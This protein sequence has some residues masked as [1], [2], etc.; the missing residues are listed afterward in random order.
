MHAHAGVCV[1]AGVCAHA[2]VCVCGFEL[3]LG[4]KLPGN[5]CFL[6]LQSKAVWF[7]CVQ[8]VLVCRPTKK[9]AH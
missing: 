7:L 3:Y 1:H 5:L 8:V 6:V 4:Q 9:Q 2:G